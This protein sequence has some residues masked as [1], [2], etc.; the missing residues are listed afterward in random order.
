MFLGDH[1]VAGQRRP[2]AIRPGRET[3]ANLTRH[4]NRLSSE[5]LYDPRLLEHD[6]CGVT[7]ITESPSPCVS[8]L[9]LTALENLTHRGA[10]GA[11][12]E[13]GDGA[14]ILIQMPEHVR[15]APSTFPPRGRVR[16]GISSA[17]DRQSA[18]AL[19]ESICAEEGLRVLGWRDVPVEACGP[20]AR[21]VAP[22]GPPQP[23]R[24]RSRSRPGA[25]SLA[26]APAQDEHADAASAPRT[27]V[28]KGMLSTEQGFFPD[29]RLTSSLALVHS[30]FSQR[31]Q[32][33]RIGSPRSPSTSNHFVTCWTGTVLLEP[34]AGRRPL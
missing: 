7:F 18:T 6:A 1:D 17:D 5:G 14:G 34:L 27:L 29:E 26:P 9:A 15:R 4:D 11:D 28:Y 19:I 32:H 22:R 20:A 13:T 33:R 30:R 16:L 8:D 10:F 31:D 3:P 23:P 21:S 24:R 12:P 2:D 25:A